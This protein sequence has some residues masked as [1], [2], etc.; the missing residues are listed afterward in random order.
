MIM[1][2]LP[3]TYNSIYVSSDAKLAVQNAQH[4]T[5]NWE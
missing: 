2:C 4:L 3:S 1:G 5:K